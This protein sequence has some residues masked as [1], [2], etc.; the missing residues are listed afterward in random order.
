MCKKYILNFIQILSIILSIMILMIIIFL[1]VML[2][3]EKEIREKDNKISEL[4]K[5]K[6]KCEIRLHITKMEVKENE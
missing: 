3:Y 5:D 6:I 2:M 4:E 1:P